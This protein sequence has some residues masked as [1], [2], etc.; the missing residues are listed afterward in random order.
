MSNLITKKKYCVES[1][2][3]IYKSLD[4]YIYICVC[5]CVCKYIFGKL[6]NKVGR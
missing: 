3:A 5:V 4:H 6:S 2:V 1:M